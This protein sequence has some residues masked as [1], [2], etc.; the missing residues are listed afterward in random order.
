MAPIAASQDNA[1]WGQAATD[2]PQ[3]QGNDA[4][5]QPQAQAADWGQPQ[6]ADQNVDWNSPAAVDDQN[7]WADPNA[8]AAT[9]WNAAGDQV[10]C[11][12]TFSYFVVYNCLSTTPH[13][14]RPLGL[15]IIHSKE[16][17]KYS[18]DLNT[19]IQIPPPLNI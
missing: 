2:Q 6:T 15:Q 19:G 8:V 12:S 4:W 1:D 7:A 3:D 10:N 11:L 17:T 5:G 14:F 13:P 16:G 9:D 18:R